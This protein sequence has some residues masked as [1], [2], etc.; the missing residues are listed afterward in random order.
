M[1][2]KLKL[3]QLMKVDIM[4]LDNHFRNHSESWDTKF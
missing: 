1:Q 4:F 3:G 2:L